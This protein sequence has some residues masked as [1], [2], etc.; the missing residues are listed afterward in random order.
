MIIVYAGSSSRKGDT[1]ARS[2][3]RGMNTLGHEADNSTRADP[4]SIILR[5]QKRVIAL[6][7]EHL[8]GSDFHIG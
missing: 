8:A 5:R 1:P 2:G 7:Y 6:G 3:V 4:V